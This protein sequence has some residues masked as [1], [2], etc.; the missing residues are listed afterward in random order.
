[1]IEDAAGLLGLVTLCFVAAAFKL[2]LPGAEV[3]QGLLPTLPEDHRASYAFLAVSILGATLSPYMLNFYASGAV[4]EKWTPKDLVTN[5]ITAG[6]GMGFGSV[7]SFGVMASAALALQPAGIRV[8]DYAQAALMLPP[9]FGRWG[10]PLFAVSLAVGCFGA[11]L[12]VSVNLAFAVAQSLG[13]NWDKNQKPAQDARFSMVYTLAIALAVLPVLLGLD[14]LRLTLFAMALT[15]MVLPLIALPF[16]VLMNDEHY[17][18][19]H[20]NGRLGNTVVGFV[21]VMG[22]LLALVAIPLEILGSS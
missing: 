8:D 18:G 1:M 4:E 12:E 6:L 14:P 10:V 7:V 20:K 9:A 21:V 19:E 3:A 17:V 22:L 5:K 16:L 13:W 15:V 11:A 2:G